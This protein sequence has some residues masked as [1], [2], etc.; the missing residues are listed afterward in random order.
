MV[1]A[2]LNGM[3]FCE[4]RI[5]KVQKP[6]V[7]Q[8]KN[9]WFCLFKWI[10]R[11][12][13][14]LSITISRLFFLKSLM[15]NP[16]ETSNSVDVKTFQK[17]AYPILFAIAFSHLLND[18]LQIIIPSIYPLLKESYSLSFTQIGLITLVYQ[19]TASL[20]QPVVGFHTD[21]KPMPFSLAFGM[22]FTMVLQSFTQRL[23]EWLI[24]LREAKEAQHRP[25]FK[26]VGTLA[27]PQVR[28]QLF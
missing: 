9:I 25:S 13:K 23:Q 27:L 22:L 4:Y 26:Q 2:L 3:H 18:L 21:K 6:N 24:W 19:L 16:S 1:A 20:L 17:T 14:C 15:N 10:G 8:L 12:F 28:C 5:F 7:L 11:L